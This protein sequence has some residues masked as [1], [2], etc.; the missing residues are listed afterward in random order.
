MYP[1]SSIKRDYLIIHVAGTE[2]FIQFTADADST[3]IDFPLVT[4]RQQSNESKIK[5]AAKELN[6]E[7][8]EARGSDGS[9]FLDCDYIGNSEQ[10]AQ[11]CRAL[12][13]IIYGATDATKLV[14]ESPTI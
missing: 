6:L 13:S 12:L 1:S 5:Q 14:F 2:D 7:F 8:H 9:R 11:V 10:A 4:E 3:Q